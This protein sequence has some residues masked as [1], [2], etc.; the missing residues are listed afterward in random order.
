MAEK[1]YLAS[2][3][4]THKG[5]QGLFNRFVRWATRS[6]YSHSELCIGDPFASAVPCLSSTGVD[7][8][9]RVKELRLS[10]EEFDLVELPGVTPEAVIDFA[11]K[12]QGEGY[13]VIG[14]VRSV[15][16]FVGREHASHWFCA[17]VCAAVIGHRE[18]WRMYPGVLHMVEDR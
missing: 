11:W 1:V 17:E 3:K 10:P 6:E 12:H 2:F 15:L 8:G 5:V 18:P 4:G 9:V 16:P 13:D 7:G 14:C